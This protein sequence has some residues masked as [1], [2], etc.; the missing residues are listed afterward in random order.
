MCGVGRQLVDVDEAQVV[1]AVWN[2]RC[3]TGIDDIDLG[4]DLVARTQP[5]LR[6]QGE[7]VVGVIVGEHLRGVQGEF[8]RGIPDPVVG[9]GLAEVITGGGALGALRVDQFGEGD[10]GGVDHGLVECAL[11]H[12]DA[13]TIRQR[14]DEFGLHG[15]AGGF[16]ERG[17]RVDEDTGAHI[18][19]MR[20]VGEIGVLLKGGHEGLEAAVGLLDPGAGRLVEKCA[21]HVAKS[22]CAVDHN[23]H[24]KAIKNTSEWRACRRDPKDVVEIE[25]TCPA[26]CEWV[27]AW[28]STSR[29]VQERRRPSV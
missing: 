18:V 3:A 21:G 13:G 26:T 27:T 14:A 1:V 11:E 29:S 4:G 7:R 23:Q 12:H 8:L 16:G 6:D 19:G 24:Q 10:A 15:A 9:A 5:S 28:A 25:F 2:L 22:C 17:R 20:V